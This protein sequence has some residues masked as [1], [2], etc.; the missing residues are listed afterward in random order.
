MNSFAPLGEGRGLAVSTRKVGVLKC[1]S[2]CSPD[3]AMHLPARNCK[4][5][6]HMQLEELAQLRNNLT[7]VR[8]LITNMPVWSKKMNGG[9]EELAQQGTAMASLYATDQTN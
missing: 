8:P 7:F 1:V 3:T 6:M 2:V 9:W 4:L 5:S